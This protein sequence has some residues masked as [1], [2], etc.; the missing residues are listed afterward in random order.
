LT[1]AFNNLA[2]L[3]VANWDPTAFSIGPVSVKWYGVS[4]VVSILIGWLYARRIVSM[5]RLWRNDTP[6]MTVTDLDDFVFWAAIGIVV[7][8]RL[9][10]ILFYDFAQF[11]AKPSAHSRYGTAACPSMAA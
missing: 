2:Y 10:Y 11:A 4:Y 3:S 6:A 8:G 1:E 9:G 7:G 5:P